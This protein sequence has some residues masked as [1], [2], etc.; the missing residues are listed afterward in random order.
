MKFLGR[1]INI[2]TEF[3]FQISQILISVHLLFKIRFKSINVKIPSDWRFGI[4]VI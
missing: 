1:D 3:F 2:V 4:L